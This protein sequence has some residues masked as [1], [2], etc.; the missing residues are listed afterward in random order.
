MC[1]CARGG[2][3]SVWGAKL[4]RCVRAPGV[5]C[6]HPRARAR[7]KEAFPAHASVKKKN[8]HKPKHHRKKHKKRFWR[9]RLRAKQ[10]VCCLFCLPVLCRRETSHAEAATCVFLKKKHKMCK[11]TNFLFFMKVHTHER[12]HTKV[13]MPTY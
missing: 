1:V 3:V 11:P 10:I 8:V 7:A 13:A 2:G 6:A 4:T 12:T 5:R 9:S